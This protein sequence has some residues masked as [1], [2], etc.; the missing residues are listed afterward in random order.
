M[1]LIE[2]LYVQEFN[3]DYVLLKIK[4]LGKIDR[5]IKRLN[6]EK[7]ILKIIDNQWELKII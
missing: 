4:Y 5:I 1:N 2:T 6:E 3:N 7:I